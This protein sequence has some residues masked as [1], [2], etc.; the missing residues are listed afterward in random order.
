MVLVAGPVSAADVAKVGTCLLANCQVA[1]ARCVGDGECL[2]NLICLQLCNGRP[3]ET[4]CQIRCGDLYADKAVEAFTACAVSDKKC[5]P[6][7]V[8]ESAYP[9]PPDCA[10]DQSFDLNN[11]QGRWY[12]TAGLN[13]LFDTFDCQVH[14][15]GVP[16]PGKL[17]GKIN[18]RIPKGNKDFIERSTVQTFD[19]KLNVSPAYL[20]NDNNEYLHY[21]DD[22]YILASKP[23]QYVVIYYRGNNDAWKGYGGATVYT[24]ESTLPQEYIPEISAAVEKAGLKWSQF[25]V[26]DN[27]CPPHPPQESLVQELEEGLEKEVKEVEYAL[28]NDL[29]SFGKGFTVI[30]KG[31]LGELQK[32]EQGL[33]QEL[34]REEK[35]AEKTIS[36]EFEQARKFVERIERQYTLPAPLR[37]LYKLGFPMPNM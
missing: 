26:T 33:V 10:L 34:V 17:Y 32:D 28:E 4:E 2:E 35:N 9:V 27:S 7:R 15:F 5:V 14:Y 31:L 8:D 11:F 3:D 37:W 6:Q 36:A 30:E 20:R 19:Q 16:E 29:T 13:P 23:D 25:K 18:W 21:T 22:W 24:R 12:I 1:L